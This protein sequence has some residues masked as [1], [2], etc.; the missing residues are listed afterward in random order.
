MTTKIHLAVDALGN[1]IRILLTGG[2]ASDIGQARKLVSGISMQWLL[3]DKGYDSDDFVAWL[4]SAN[5]EA[6]I[7]PRSNRKSPRDYDRHWYKQRNLVERANAWLKRFRR[8]ATRYDKT[9]RNYLGFVTLG[10]IL[11]LLR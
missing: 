9:A 5:V 6:V 3:G 4:N 10:A 2:Q 7:P 1:P 8:I 11:M